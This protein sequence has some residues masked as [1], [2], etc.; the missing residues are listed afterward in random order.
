MAGFIHRSCSRATPGWGCR[1]FSAETT[2]RSYCQVVGGSFAPT[3]THVRAV[4]E[5]RAPTGEQTPPAAGS[6]GLTTF[7][8]AIADGDPSSA[9]AKNTTT[10][11]VVRLWS[12]FMEQC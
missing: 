3:R 7:F 11:V 2:L 6:L 9:A 1:F 8:A 4:P 12:A 5:A 10:N